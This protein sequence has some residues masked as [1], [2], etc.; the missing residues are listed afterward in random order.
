MG[1]TLEKKVDRVADLMQRMKGE[2]QKVLPKWITAERMARVVLTEFRKVP[3]LLDCT[4]VSLL[5]CVMQA[6]E[7]G[8]EPGSALN[9]AYLIPFRD[10]CTLIIG[11]RGLLELARRS[12]QVKDIYSEVVR[13]NDEFEYAL[14]L[15]PKLEHKPAL[16]D[17]GDAIFVYAVAHLKDGGHQFEVMTVEEVNVIRDKALSKIRN[18][19]DTPW[20]QHWGAMAR[21]TLLRR[22]CKYLPAAVLPREVQDVLAVE[23]EKFYADTTARLISEGTKKTTGD[24]R[25]RLEE[26]TENPE[27]REPVPLNQKDKPSVEKKPVW[28]LTEKRIH[29]ILAAAE[30][31]G[32]SLKQMEVWMAEMYTVQDGTAM[33]LEK[34]ESEEVYNEILQYFSETVQA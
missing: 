30:K 26:R 11:F 32:W 8:L 2:F 6:A 19:K 12:G 9:Q 24:L 33:T 29:K 31:N 25:K 23:D 1:K 10:E 14:G 18:Q 21:K 13:A 34:I 16:K 27:K 22:L 17:R 20:V 7:L 5:K 15:N 3:K 28:S 4:D